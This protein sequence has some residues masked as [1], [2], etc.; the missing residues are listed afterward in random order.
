ML[1]TVAEKGAGHV[2]V[3]LQGDL[4]ARPGGGAVL[5]NA[6]FQ[7]VVKETAAGAGD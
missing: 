1:K 2:K 4:V 3:I 6:G 7:V 5:E